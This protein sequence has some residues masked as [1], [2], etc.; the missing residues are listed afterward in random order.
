MSPAKIYHKINQGEGMSSKERILLVNG[1][2][3][4]PANNFQGQANVLIEEGKI[5]MVGKETPKADLRIEAGGLYVLPGL[6]DMHVHLREPGHEEEETIE[7]GTRA[8]VAGGFTSVACMPNTHPAIDSEATVDFVLRQASEKGFCRVYPVGA[9]T[10]N[11]E[12]KELAEMGTMV[13]AG[14]VAF[15]DDGEGVGDTAVAYR[16]MQYATMFGK[17]II[18][19]CEDFSLTN[20]GSMNGGWTATLLGLPGRPALA[21]QIMLYRDLI[22]A[23][24]TECKYHA[25][26]VSTAASVELIREAKK[27]GI[28]NISAEA[29][30]HH[31][32]LTDENCRNFDSNYKVAPPL[33]TAKDIAALKAGLAD[34]TIDCLVTDHAPHCREEKEL[35]FLYAPFGIIGLEVAL[36]LYSKALIDEKV[37]NWMDLV[38]KMTINPARILGIDKGTLSVNADADVTLVDPNAP[39]T[40]D[41]DR[42]FSRSRNCP[43]HGWKV[44]GKVIGTLVAGQ[45]RHNDGLKME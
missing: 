9:I 37:L 5:A 45:I 18:Q 25:A 29:T 20:G 33:R 13:R 10:K 42:F 30:P 15:S 23:E 8:A 1:F 16:A 35:E 17:T 32:L 21:E 36:P 7:T 6:I 26:H 19:H 28:K 2:V 34:G 11:R 24:S 31:L 43:Y 41:V 22:L 40:I 39:W 3:V 27:K 44:R 12:G 14:A 4:D 38:A